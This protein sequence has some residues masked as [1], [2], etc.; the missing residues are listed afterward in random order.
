MFKDRIKEARLK[1]KLTQEQLANL[2]GI[3]KSTLAGYERGNSE[4][5]L[6]RIA[7]MMKV[8]KV[9][10]NYLWQDEMQTYQ[11]GSRSITPEGHEMLQ[12]YNALDEHGKCMVDFVIDE[13]YKRCSNSVLMKHNGNELSKSFDAAAQKSNNVRLAR[14]ETDDGLKTSTQ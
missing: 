8:L 5:D 13:E 3:A 9:D 7:L 14:D 4:P 2:I 6:N 1:E 11:A 12:K 10:A